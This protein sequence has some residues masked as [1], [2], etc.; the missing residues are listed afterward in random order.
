LRIEE[1][2]TNISRERPATL[3]ERAA[4]GKGR[5]GKGGKETGGREGRG[6]NRGNGEEKGRPAWEIK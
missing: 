4:S 5:E 3:V 1:G 2:A 6:V